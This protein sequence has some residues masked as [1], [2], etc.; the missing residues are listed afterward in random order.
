MG[1][2]LRLARRSGRAKEAAMKEAHMRHWMRAT[3][4]PPCR[5]LVCCWGRRPSGS[6]PKDDKSM[7]G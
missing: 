4:R 5:A 1:V 6:A 2:G 3:Y 7:P